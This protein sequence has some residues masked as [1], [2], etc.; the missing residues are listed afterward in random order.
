MTG[1][2]TGPLAPLITTCMDHS[3][4][5]A[6]HA[7]P[8]VQTMVPPDDRV[9]VPGAVA[10][11][12]AVSPPELGRDTS[13]TTSA[14]ELEPRY[15]QRQVLLNVIVALEPTV[16]EITHGSTFDTTDA[17]ELTVAPHVDVASLA[18]DAALD[19]CTARQNDITRIAT[20]AP[21]ADRSAR[22]MSAQF[23]RRVSHRITR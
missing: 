5:S 12:V 22:R 17:P 3:R 10:V 15:V 8:D 9:A 20:M 6:G 1:N 2:V 21:D 7:T 16:I 13:D 23:I 11:N 18:C 14:V 4:A 19:G